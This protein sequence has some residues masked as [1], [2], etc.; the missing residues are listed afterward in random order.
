MA[1]SLELKARILG[2]MKCDWEFEITRID[3]PMRH[4]YFFTCTIGSYVL[5][6]SFPEFNKIIFLP[7]W[8]LDLLW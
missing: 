5:A 8:L 2:N 3:G 7:S 4:A 1:L 6:Y